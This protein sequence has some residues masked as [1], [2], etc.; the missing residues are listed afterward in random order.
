M[1][2]CLKSKPVRDVRFRRAWAA[3]RDRCQVCGI[4]RWFSQPVSGLQVHHIIKSG[5]SDEACNLLLVCDECHKVI[6]GERVVRYDGSRREPLT[7]A[8]VLWF[9]QASDPE[10][11]NED[12][13]TILYRHRQRTEKYRPLPEPKK[14]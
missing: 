11:Y 12:R 2:E 5:R 13:L 6:E 3:E 1:L 8:N 9:K 4:N 14:R 7:L 10:E